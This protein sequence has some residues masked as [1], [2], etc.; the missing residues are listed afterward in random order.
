MELFHQT[1]KI[2][3]KGRLR[4]TSLKATSCGG[5]YIFT[6]WNNRPE[7]VQQRTTQQPIHATLEDP[8]VAHC[9]TVSIAAVNKGFG[10]GKAIAGTLLIN[11]VVGILG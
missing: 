6:E 1:K 5:R 9:K 8:H 4:H 7:I 10:P 11:P 2:S 3:P